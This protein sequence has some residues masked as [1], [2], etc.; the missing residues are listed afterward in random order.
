MRGEPS[1]LVDPAPDLNRINGIQRLRCFGIGHLT[2][3]GTEIPSGVKSEPGAG[4]D[5]YLFM[6]NRA[7]NDGAG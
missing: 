4:G 1:T 3:V 2:T 5:T 6:R 7:E